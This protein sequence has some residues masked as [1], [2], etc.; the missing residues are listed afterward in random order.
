MTFISQ[1]LLF[2]AIASLYLVANS[3]FSQFWL[4]FRIVSYYELELWVIKSNSEGKKSIFLQLWVYNSQFGRYNSQLRD[5]SQ[6]LEFISRNSEKKSHNCEIKSPVI[7][8]F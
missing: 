3:D 1:F 8:Y 4:F 2:L 7:V 5:K 6:N